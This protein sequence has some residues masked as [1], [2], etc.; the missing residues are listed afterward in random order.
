MI[1]KNKNNKIYEN[2]L[3][4]PIGKMSRSVMPNYNKN[5]SG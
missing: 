3:S 2:C 4:L 5:Y 1:A